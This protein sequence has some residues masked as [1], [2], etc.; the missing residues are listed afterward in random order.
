MPGDFF[1]DFIPPANS[2][3]MSLEGSFPDPGSEQ[4]LWST[5]HAD[6]PYTTFNYETRYILDRGFVHV[7][8]AGPDGTPAGIVKA[9]A[10]VAQKVVSW[11]ATR[12]GAKPAL[13]AIEADTD[14]QTFAGYVLIPDAPAL[15]SDGLVHSYKVRGA[16]RYFLATP[17]PV[18][19]PLEMGSTPYDTTSPV[20][21]IIMPADFRLMTTGG[22]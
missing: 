22:S 1:S 5:D 3:D 20:N 2:G 21:N 15:E 8:A 13:P 16:Y 17:P 12:K 6:I 18:T 19:G 10:A 14:N 7:P 4:A 9:H 11:T